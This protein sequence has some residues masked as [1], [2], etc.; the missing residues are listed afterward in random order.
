MRDSIESFTS[1]EQ[2]MDEDNT[3]QTTSN[4]TTKFYFSA[5]ELIEKLLD[6]GSNEMN[7]FK[8]S[9]DQ[10]KKID[11][12]NF[13]VL[14]S[15]WKQSFNLFGSANSAHTVIKGCLLYVIKQYLTQKVVADKL[16]KTEA[17]TAFTSYIFEHGLKEDYALKLIRS[18][19][20]CW[21]IYTGKYKILPYKETWLRHF[22]AQWLQDKEQHS[23]VR[24]AWHFVE[25]IVA[26]DKRDEPTQ[27]ITRQAVS[28]VINN[29]DDINDRDIDD[30]N[31]SKV[32]IGDSPKKRPSSPRSYARYSWSNSSSKKSKKSTN[33]KSSRPEAPLPDA[34]PDQDLL[35]GSFTRNGRTDTLKHFGDIDNALNGD[36]EPEEETL[37]GK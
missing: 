33:T 12:G 8:Q 15:N 7:N 29:I 34:P 19:K 32:D 21:I 24:K 22:P 6:I 28:M 20:A 31:Y 36:G 4:A 2:S 25:L 10:I 5:V 35:G 14:L 17:K 18:A 23:K 1:V 11:Q 27:S 3:S 9:I 37:I 13:S 16:D 26:A 30:A